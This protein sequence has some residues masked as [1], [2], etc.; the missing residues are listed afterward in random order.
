MS[1]DNSV[2]IISGGTTYFL[3]GSTKTAYT[4]SG[5][6]WTAENTSPYRL[7]LN[8]ATPIWVPQAASAAMQYTGGP[9]FRLGAAPVYRGYDNLTESVGVHMY[10]T[11]A[12]N[13]IFLLRQ[14]RQ[15]LNTALFT[16]PPLLAVQSGTNTTY[17]EIYSADVQETSGYLVEGNSTAQFMRA[18]I[19]WVRSPLGGSA[20]LTTAINAQTFTNNNSAGGANLTLGTI[21]GDLANEG[22]PLNITITPAAAKIYW[23]AYLATIASTAYTATASTLTTTSSSAFTVASVNFAA[24]RNNRALKVRVCGHVSTITNPNKIQLQMRIY[25]SV[26]S[27]AP[28]AS[29][30][31]T[32]GSAT[33]AQYVD[34]GGY[35]LDFLRDHNTSTLNAL[36]EVTLVSSDGTSVTATLTGL[37]VI[38]YY[39]WALVQG[40]AALMSNASST[41]LVTLGANNANGTAYVP[42][43]TTAYTTGNSS[44]IPTIPTIVRGTLPRAWSG[45]KLMIILIANPSGTDT[46]ASTDTFTVT[47]QYLPVYQTLRG[48]N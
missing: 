33:T 36:V 13:A 10:A 41:R 27:A 44:I 2:S 38:F 31:M 5:T 23:Q 19:T 9:P 16:Y 34:F 42:I 6:P 47:A 12:D 18:T 21:T 28:F 32:L 30:T 48:N 24:L 26:S 22:Q 4:G 25:P 17:Y 39:D 40:N 45:G 37:E 20:S 35:S 14:L 46:Y 1:F 8:D 7:S 15:I 11:S 43:P 29:K 3:S